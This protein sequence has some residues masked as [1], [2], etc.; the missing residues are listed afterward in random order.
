MG[1]VG[2][3]K[4]KVVRE[5]ARCRAAAVPRND[6]RWDGR[7]ADVA[8]LRSVYAALGGGVIAW[9]LLSVSRVSH[10]SHL[11]VP[12]VVASRLGKRHI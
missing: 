6:Y 11:W 2:V 12:S 4:R 1:S 5:Q 10:V 3:A 9:R 8:R 7:D